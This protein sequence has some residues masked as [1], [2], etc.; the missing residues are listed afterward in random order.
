MNAAYLKKCSFERD[1]TV[2]YSER[3]TSQ[4]QG[5]M[6]NVLRKFVKL[7]GGILISLRNKTSKKQARTYIYV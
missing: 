3:I 2:L 6:P 7:R 5:E 4:S 1:V